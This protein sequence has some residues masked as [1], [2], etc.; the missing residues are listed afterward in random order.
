MSSGETKRTNSVN[1]TN[2]EIAAATNQANRDIAQMNN[3]FNLAMLD[4]QIAYNKEAYQRQFQ[5][6]KDFT[7]EMWNRNN[8]YNSPSAQMQRLDEAGINP[9]MAM[10]NGMLGSGTSSGSG[11]YSAP[12]MAGIDTPTASPYTAVG[13]TAV[14]PDVSANLAASAQIMTGIN[15][16]I[17][18][19]VGSY[20]GNSQISALTQGVQLDNELK[21]RT[22]A[23]NVGSALAGL[24]GQEA[25]NVYQKIVNGFTPA[26]MSSNLTNSYLQNQ[27][28]MITNAINDVNLQSLPLQN[29]M[30]IGS[31]AA[32]IYSKLQNG[33][34]SAAQYKKVLNEAA[35]ELVKQDLMSKQGEQIYE[36]TRGLKFDNDQKYE[37]V[38]YLNSMIRS[39]AK[40]EENKALP[41]TDQWIETETN[42]YFRNF[43]RFID[44]VTGSVSPLK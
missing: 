35:T 36:Q 5:D 38:E 31:V 18:D 30:A 4:K 19:S 8:E 32:D 33:Q 10:G 43:Y 16:V 15:K 42:K 11:Q 6:T 3:E 13:Y 41:N 39:R 24:Q 1:Q 14:K 23:L 7:L 20:Y 40:Q 44:S 27:G 28:Q 17:N 21:S 29:R 25:K 22:M 12:N 26:L 9:Y 2:K 34:L 37:M